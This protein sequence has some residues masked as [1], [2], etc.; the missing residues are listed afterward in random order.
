MSLADLLGM[1]RLELARQ[2]TNRRIQ[3]TEALN[4]PI[5]GFASPVLGVDDSIPELVALIVAASGRW[6][7][8]AG[9]AALAAKPIRWALVPV[10][11]NFRPVHTAWLAMFGVLLI[12]GSGTAW[13]IL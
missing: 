4:I 8:L 3:N 6:V 7:I 9:I 10:A 1:R 13:M 2:S 11:N 5:P 12:I